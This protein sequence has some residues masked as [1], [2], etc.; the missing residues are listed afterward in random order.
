[1]IGSCRSG[2]GTACPTT[3]NKTTTGAK[4]GA[5]LWPS[6]PHP[7][8]QVCAP[9]GRRTCNSNGEST[10]ARAGRSTGVKQPQPT[11]Q[12]SEPIIAHYISSF[13]CILTG[14][15]AYISTLFSKSCSAKFQKVTMFGLSSGRNPTDLVT[16]MRFAHANF[17]LIST[18]Y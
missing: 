15:G 1:M 12:I 18:L 16:Q 7:A 11:A 6:G 13:Y 3:D 2:R 10:I 8:V 4:D 9:R 17:Q 14:Q 5:E